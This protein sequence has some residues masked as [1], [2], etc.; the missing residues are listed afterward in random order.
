MAEARRLWEPASAAT[1]LQP[2]Y[3]GAVE[4]RARS[5]QSPTASASHG[6]FVVDSQGRTRPCDGVGPCLDGSPA[7]VRPLR[8]A[9]ADA[10]AGRL[11]LWPTAPVLWGVYLCSLLWFVFVFG[12]IWHASGR[13]DGPRTWA[14]L[15]RLGVLLGV[16]RMSGEAVVLAAPQLVARLLAA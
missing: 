6:A 5:A 16:V 15:A 13:Y 2:A 1:T 12:A 14:L 11:P 10:W 3:E 7:G 4:A 9:L 8:R